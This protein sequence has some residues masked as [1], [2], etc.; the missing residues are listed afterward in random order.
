[1]PRPAAFS[2]DDEKQML[3]QEAQ[4]LQFELDRIKKR[5]SGISST[6]TEE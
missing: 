2:P 5:L 6:K 1:M 4:G 3:E